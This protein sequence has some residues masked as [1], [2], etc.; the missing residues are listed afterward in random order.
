MPT[1]SDELSLRHCSNIILNPAKSCTKHAR[2]IFFAN[3]CQFKVFLPRFLKFIVFLAKFLQV[4]CLPCKILASSMS[5]LQDSCKTSCKNN[6]L[7]CKVLQDVS[8]V[9]LQCLYLCNSRTVFCC[10]IAFRLLIKRPP[11][12]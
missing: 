7:F 2:Y 11:T 6:A 10:P 3:S 1:C 9:F 5:F 8:L 12:F 4:Q